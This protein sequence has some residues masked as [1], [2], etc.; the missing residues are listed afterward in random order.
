MGWLALV[1]LCVRT[2]TAAVEDTRL[3]GRN[4]YLG[5]KGT[6]PIQALCWHRPC[7]IQLGG[8]RSM[9]LCALPTGGVGPRRM[10]GKFGPLW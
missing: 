5:R 1:R 8:L 10:A 6:S 7:N 3:G 9:S 4:V 2:I